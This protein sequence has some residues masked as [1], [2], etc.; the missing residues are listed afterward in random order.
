MEVNYDDPILGDNEHFQI[1]WWLPFNNQGATNS[2]QPYIFLLQNRHWI[3]G[4]KILTSYYSTY[5]CISKSRKL[6]LDA[7]IWWTLNA[8]VQKWY[9]IFETRV[10]HVSARVVDISDM[11]LFNFTNNASRRIETN[12]KTSAIHQLNCS[13]MC[14]T[15]WILE[16]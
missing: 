3:K 14:D 8:A 11:F 2:C 7:N 10:T 9:Q 1:F 12:W 5:V 4:R 6:S 16:V 15:T 13:C